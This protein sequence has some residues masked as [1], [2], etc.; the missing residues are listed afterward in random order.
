[1][2]TYLLFL[3]PVSIFSRL[4]FSLSTIF[5]SDFLYWLAII[6][7]FLLTVI[8]AHRYNE[9]KTNMLMT[10]LVT[11]PFTLVTLLVR[12]LAFSVIIAF[13]PQQYTLLLLLGLFTSLLVV[14]IIFIDFESCSHQDSQGDMSTMLDCC[15]GRKCSLVFSCLPR[16][17]LKAVADILIPVGYNKNTNSRGSWL[18]FFNYLIVMGGIGLSLWHSIDHHIPNTYNGLNMAENGLRV[19]IPDTN[20]VLKTEYGMDIKVG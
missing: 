7:S 19:E 6:S 12:L 16:L 11:F 10:V 13:M 5:P 2:T 3:K 15:I 17:L 18:I 9:G 14:N 8:G 4:H 20:L 1:M